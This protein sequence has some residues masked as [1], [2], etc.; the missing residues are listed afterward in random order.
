MGK[1]HC[2]CQDIQTCSVFRGNVQGDTKPATRTKCF[3]SIF[4]YGK[5][6]FYR[7]LL[8]LD[9]VGLFKWT[10]VGVALLERLRML[11]K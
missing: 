6:A 5:Y 9:A 8:Q 2:E 11:K 3:L 4:Y 7:I 1:V 10:N